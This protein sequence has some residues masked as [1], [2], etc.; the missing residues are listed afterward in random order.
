MILTFD[1]VQEILHSHRLLMSQKFETLGCQW[2][3]FNQFFADK[4]NSGPRFGIV[5]QPFYYLK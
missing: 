3:G 1:I 5:D 2:C 4:G